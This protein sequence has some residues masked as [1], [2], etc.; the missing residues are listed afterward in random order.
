MDD[1]VKQAVSLSLTEVFE[2]MFFTLLEPLDGIPARDEWPPEKDF[3]MAE[4]SYSGGGIVGELRFY[5][6]QSL[7]RSIAMNFLGE[8][9][10]SLSE[11]QLVDT[12]RETVNMGVGSMLGRLD[13]AG[14]CTLG[15]PKARLVDDFSPEAIV[16]ELGLYVF[17]TASGFLWL[18]YRTR[19]S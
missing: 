19:K 9:E 7:A 1:N 16:A 2:T 11:G 17:R 6:P 15:I 14:E 3:V 13:P 8:Q 18:E 12:V 10:D 5:F 4:I